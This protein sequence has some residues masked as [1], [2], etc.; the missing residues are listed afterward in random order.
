[1]SD[2][3]V[4]IVFKATDNLT[5]SLNQMRNSTKG[6]TKDI[7]QYKKIQNEAFKQKAKLDID[8]TQAKSKLKDMEKAYKEGKDVSRESLEAQKK[9]VYQLQEAY[10]RLGKIV[11]ESSKGQ[12]NLTQEINKSKNMA[13]I[14]GEATSKSLFGKLGQVELLKM[15]GSAAIDFG[16]FQVNSAYGNKVGNAVSNIGG[17]MV[18]FGIAGGMVGGPVGA[19]VG[20]GIGLVAGA[21]KTITDEQKNKDDLFREDIKG[22]ITE[23][24]EHQRQ[25]TV[26]GS[27]LASKREQDQI[28]FATIYKSNDAAEKLLK[29]IEKFSMDTPLESDNLIDLAKKLSSYQFKE[30]EIVPFAK[31]LGDTNAALGGKQEDMEWVATALGRMRSSDKASLEFINI[32]NDRAIPAIKYLAEGMGVSQ[33]QI[34][35]MISKNQISGTTAFK[36]ITDGMK[37]DFNGS[38]NTLANTFQGVKSNLDEY[39]A[40]KDR[41]KGEGYNNE[42]K[43]GMLGE[44][45]WNEQNKDAIMD[46][47]KY[48]GAYEA[49]LE[50]IKAREMNLAEE[51]MRNSSEFKIAFGRKDEAEMG[52]L[53]ME[54]RAQGAIEYKKTQEFQTMQKADLELVK[55]LQK[56]ANINA[57]Y[58]E[59]G[60]EYG[61]Q[62]SKG[63]ETGM[64]R[65]L[66]E[67]VKGVKHFFNKYILRKEDEPQSTATGIFDNILN[68]PKDNVPSSGYKGVL[69]TP[70]TPKIE[71][72]KIVNPYTKKAFAIGLDR[73]PYDNYPALLHEGERVLTKAEVN[74]KKETI[75]PIINMYNTV[76]DDSDIDKIA[77]ALVVK[78]SMHQESYGGEY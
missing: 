32:L 44:I 46:T 23:V 40:L 29:S 14:Q 26:R 35:D 41:A 33:K 45:A 7:E 73:V 38:M 12:M 63:M 28:S 4:G 50:N 39:Q 54:A 71:L 36:V 76:R 16:A 22:M 31:I 57:A 15:A 21:A 5:N 48:L 60:V 3:E 8:I 27:D 78:L 56:D 20:A 66:T 69:N 43:N 74:S 67:S 59:A 17:S 55:S 62:L 75:Q 51:R 10:S 18:N 77:N 25:S 70:Q 11:K 64:T 9:E 30:E 52:R 65:A 2:R 37:R 6:L 13:N 49:K 68:K 34:Y 58:Y 42:R 24:K 61:N 1:M 72:P 53:I 47:N 19:A